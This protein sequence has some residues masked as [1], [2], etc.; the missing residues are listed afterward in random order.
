MCTGT[1]FACVAACTRRQ[2]ASIQRAFPCPSCRTHLSSSACMPDNRPFFDAA[3]DRAVLQVGLRIIIAFWLIVLIGCKKR[4]NL[5]FLPFAAFILF[6]YVHS[7]CSTSLA[8]IIIFAESSSPIEHS[9]PTAHSPLKGSRS[10]DLKR[11]E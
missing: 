3:I 4:V 7:H 11:G 6:Y 8:Q 5:I 10:G 9:S 2:A 1:V